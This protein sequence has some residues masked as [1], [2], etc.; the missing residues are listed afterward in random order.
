MKSILVPIGGS[1]TDEAVFQT[2]MAVARPFASHLEFIHVRIGPGQAAVYA[3]HVGFASGPALL[4]ALDHLDA[5]SSARADLAMRHVSEF[6]AR[7]GITLTDAPGPASGITARFRV[8]ENDARRRLLYHARHHDLVVIGRAKR[9]NGLPP[10]LLESLLM[11]CGRPI[12]LASASTPA[13]LVGTVMVCWRETPDAARAMVAAMPLLTR[14]KR[15]VFAAVQEGDGDIAEA[16]SDVAAQFRWCGVPAEV[17]VSA[18]NGRPTPDVLSSMARDCGADLVV[19]GA[20]G[21]SPVR[22][23]L[24]GGCTQAVI[25]NGDRPVLLLH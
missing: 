10:D 14:A 5:N 2:A 8:E 1:D 25:Q 6:C 22:E 17:Q 11:G 18:R 24:F 15:V 12:L 4:D 7:A 13:E 20:F 21:H 9:P 23:I 16:V 3:P 19:M